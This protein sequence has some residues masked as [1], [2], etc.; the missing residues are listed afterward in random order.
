MWY[1]VMSK[2][3]G[4]REA[5]RGLENENL[6]WMRQ[7]HDAGSVLF[8]GPTTEGV[9]I[10]V[11]RAANREAAKALLASHPWVMRGLRDVSEIYEWNVQQALGIGRF[12]GPPPQGTV[13]GR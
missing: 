9:G 10:W 3:I 12:E 11:I 1:V 5:I 7:Q 13:P 8:S 6:S 4:P 2:S